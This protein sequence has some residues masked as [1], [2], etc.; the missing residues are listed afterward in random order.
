MHK[1]T[2]AMAGVLAL[3]GALTGCDDYLTGSGL[4]DDPNRPSEGNLAQVFQGVQVTQF[5]FHTGDLARVSSMWMQQMAGIGR[6]QQSRDLYEITEDD[7]DTDFGRIYTGG[8]LIDLRRI[9]ELAPDDRTYQGISKV[10]EA[11]TMGMA[12]SLWGDIPYSGAV[13]E[14][15]ATPTLDQQAAVYAAIQTLL[16]EAIADLNAG[17]GAGPGGLDLVF[18][19]DNDL[20]ARTAYTLKA[21][22]YM[23]WVE[24]QGAAAA[25]PEWLGSGNPQTLANTACAGNCLT[26]AV[27]AAQNGI[28]AGED[29]TSY[30]SS[31]AGEQNLWWQFTNVAR[32]GDIGAGENLVELL[33]ARNDPRLEVYF[34]PGPG[35]S[36]II[37]AP[38]GTEVPEAAILNPLARGRADFRQPM[39][40]Y[41]ETQLILAEAQLRLNPANLAGPLG[42]LNSL[43]DDVGLAP[44]AGAAVD[45]YDE[46]LRAIAEEKYIALF[47]NMEA[48]NDHKRLCWPVLT[49]ASGAEHL[50]GR[51]Y[52][53]SRERNANPNIP[54]PG[55]LTE[56]NANDPLSCEGYDEDA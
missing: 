36:E 10:W 43:R 47:Q 28:Q 27:A 17:S 50:P 41:E 33:K 30:H 16:D 45:S 20:W 15:N 51:L 13:T 21:R 4:T 6:Q 12:A 18:G 49:P 56:R 55:A 44:L 25:E 5:V 53:G 24:A 39:A 8:G 35:A 37:G 23:H 22:F 46:V 2:L 34:A 54:S 3:A 31:S 26:K 7:F 29:F 40:T 32:V 52:Y 1:R 48:W 19:G 38:S 9:R 14:G 42:L 11:Y